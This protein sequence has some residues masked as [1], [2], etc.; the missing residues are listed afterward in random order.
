MHSHQ[1][2]LFELAIRDAF[3]PLGAR[4]GL[5]LHAACDGVYEFERSGYAV[6]VRR[7]IGHKKDI[8]VTLVPATGQ[9]VTTHI[10]P[11]E[12]G[13][14][15]IAELN[16]EALPPFEIDSDEDYLKSARLLAAAAGRFALPYLTGERSD[17]ADLRARVDESIANWK[18]DRPDYLRPGYWTRPPEA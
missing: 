2:S 18:R 8:L 14:G 3:A 16:G 12:I 11:G 9:P 6:R 5:A 4:A 17:F 10:A 13:L 15:L 1:Q 7:G